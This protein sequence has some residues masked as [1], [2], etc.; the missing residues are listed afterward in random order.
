M[1][2]RIGPSILK[3]FKPGTLCAD[4][5]L[6]HNR[7][8]AARALPPETRMFSHGQG[9]ALV[10][11]PLIREDETS[12][13]APNMNFAIHPT[14]AHGNSVFTT[15]CDNFIVGADGSME[16]IHTTEQKVFE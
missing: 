10:E 4:I 8:R 9:Y 13:V 15:M 5:L 12:V 1:A 14:I 2:P 3:A 11:R 6:E 7:D 16:R